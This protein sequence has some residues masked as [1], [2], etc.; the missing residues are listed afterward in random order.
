M[1]AGAVQLRR[2]PVTFPQL[3]LGLLS[4]AVAAVWIAHIFARTIHDA[5]HTDDTIEITG[6]AGVPIASN[7]VGWSLTVDGSA[8][9][10]VAAALRQRRESAAVVAFLRRAGIRPAAISSEVVHSETETNRIDKHH[11]RTTY[12]VYQGIVVSTAAIDLVEAASTRIG[13]LLER[14][15]AVSA[16]P[17]AYVSTDLEQAKLDALRAAVAEAKR[18]AEILVDGL[19]GKL[20]RMRATSLGVYQITPR[21]S[22]EVSDYGVNDTS[23]RLKDVRAVVSARFAVE[24]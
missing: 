22:T 4:L 12:H 2:V 6:S 18:R 5:K 16:E 13:D 7:R 10:P 24:S 1:D 14:G 19:G 3:F 9:T 20:G 15:V 23:S 11:T 17:L 21:N 8:A